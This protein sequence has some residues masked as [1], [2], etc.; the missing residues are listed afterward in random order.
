MHYRKIVKKKKGK[1]SYSFIKSTAR[2]RDL[3]A[4]LT[5]EKHGSVDSQT[6]EKKNESD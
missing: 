2:A 5:K 1:W 3:E 4:I 6:H